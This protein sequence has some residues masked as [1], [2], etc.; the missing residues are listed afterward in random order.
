MRNKKCNGWCGAAAILIAAL[1]AV[2]K[3]SLL[4]FPDWKFRLGTFWLRERN[5]GKCGSVDKSAT[6]AKMY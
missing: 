1:M 3:E 5:F 4:T 2:V 6:Y